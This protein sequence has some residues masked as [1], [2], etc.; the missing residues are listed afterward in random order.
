MVQ[1][2]VDLYMS[3]I[4]LTCSER[5]VSSSWLIQIESIQKDFR[6]VSLR[7]RRKAF[8]RFNLTVNNCSST[9]IL[10]LHQNLKIWN[11]AP[12]NCVRWH[13]K[14]SLLAHSICWSPYI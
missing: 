9:K 13:Q 7:M 11:G 4:I 2:C 3:P 1:S 14:G 6:S 8:S 10:H 12:S 5:S